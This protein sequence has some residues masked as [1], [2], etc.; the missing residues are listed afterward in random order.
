MRGGVVKAKEKAASLEEA[1]SSILAETIFVKHAG[2]RP[3]CWERVLLFGVIF[4]FRFPMSP[5]GEIPF[6]GLHS[7][8]LLF[9]SS[10]L[11]LCF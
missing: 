9:L 7:F 4:G 8:L 5:A 11:T 2:H 6:Y 3:K 10:L 1:R